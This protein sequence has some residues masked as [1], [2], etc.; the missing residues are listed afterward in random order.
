MLPRQAHA[1][2]HLFTRGGQAGPA[3]QRGLLDLAHSHLLSVA[4][5]AETPSPFV[6]GWYSL[7]WE[8]PFTRLLMDDGSDM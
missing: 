2:V 7:G 6:A 3:A 5:A 4:L 1:D 8:L